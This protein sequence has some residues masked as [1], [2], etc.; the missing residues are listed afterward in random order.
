ME[1]RHVRIGCARHAEAVSDVSAGLFERKR[2][3][4][5]AH[6]NALAHLAKSRTLKHFFE[7]WLAAQ[8]D[9]Q[10][11]SMRG[12]QV[13]KH[14][15]L[16]DHIQREALRFVNDQDGG[17]AGAKAILQPIGKMSKGRSSLWNEGNA[18]IRQDQIEQLAHL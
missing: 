12:L 8:D 4:S 3:T 1:N 15:Q 17:F 18:E 6:R 7:L 2:Q 11:V 5:A 9:L 13:Q 16:F 10:E 14:A